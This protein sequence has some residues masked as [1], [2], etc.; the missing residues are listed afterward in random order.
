[1]F[2]TRSLAASFVDAGTVRLSREGRQ[3]RIDKASRMVRPGDELVFVRDGRVVQLT[4]VDL[5]VRRG[6]PAEAQTLYCAKDAPSSG[7]TAP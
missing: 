4:V 3:T 2:K 1:M 5:G 7:L 6:P